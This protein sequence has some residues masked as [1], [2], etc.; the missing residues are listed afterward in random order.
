MVFSINFFPSC[1][2]RVFY[3]QKSDAFDDDLL[4]IQKSIQ[5]NHPG[6]CNS[7][8]PNFS[9]TFEEN[10]NIAKQ[11]LRQATSD[12]EKARV[13]QEFGRKFHDAHLWIQYDQKRVEAST[14]S[15]MRETRAF[16]IQEL[17]KGIHWVDIPTFCPRKDQITIL[18][19]IIHKLAR[20]REQT[21][22]FDLRGNG[23]GSSSW[24]EELLKA[25]FSKEYVE[26]RLAEWNRDVFIE[27]RVSPGN[28]EHVKTVISMM[29]N[30]FEGKH[31]ALQLAEKI[32]AG[33]E[34]ALSRGEPSY[35]ESKAKTDLSPFSNTQNPFKGKVF[36]IIDGGCGSACLDFIDGLK[37]MKVNLVLV[38]KTTGKDSSYMELRTISLP[39][40]QGKLGFPIKVYRNRPRG[41]NVS[42]TPDIRY[43]CHLQ[44]TAKLQE[45]VL[46]L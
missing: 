29:K 23:G 41:H 13:L 11:E 38:G 3:T 18:N 2:E 32:V 8:D 15:P 1:L 36:A 25:L 4:F 45:F 14:T 12:Q 7:L 34:A 19:S 24:G 21:V 26:Q 43:D 44:D 28:L 6:I 10:F 31:P 9:K 5:E 20:L 39:S 30:E 16:G 22:V 46:K 33:M 17:K 35:F 42:Y 27:W 40:G 37:A